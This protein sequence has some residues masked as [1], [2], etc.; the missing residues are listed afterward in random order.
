M[1]FC[2]IY[3]LLLKTR[4]ENAARVLPQINAGFQYFFEVFLGIASPFFKA[5]VRKRKPR[6]RYFF[7]SDTMRGKKAEEEAVGSD[8][9]AIPKQT[10]HTSKKTPFFLETENN[11]IKREKKHI[12]DR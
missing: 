3:L 4:L 1:R 11:E 10:Q 12:C 9:T 8:F 6:K 7:R 2:S 5:V